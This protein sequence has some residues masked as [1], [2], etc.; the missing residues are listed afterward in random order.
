MILDSAHVCCDRCTFFFV[1][2]SI[3]HLSLELLTKFW[4]MSI[5]VAYQFLSFIVHF[6]TI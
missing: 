5:K 6:Y 2:N 1:G 3:Y 4:K